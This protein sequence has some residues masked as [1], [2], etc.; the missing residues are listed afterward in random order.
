MIEKKLIDN[1]QKSI[2]NHKQSLLNCTPAELSNIQFKI[3]HCQ[4]L[5]DLIDNV[6]KNPESEISF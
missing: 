6:V 3:R 2:A 1:I 5:I 4:S